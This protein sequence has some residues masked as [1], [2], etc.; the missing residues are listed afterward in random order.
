[1]RITE[2]TALVVVDAQIDFFEGGALAVPGSNA[3]LPAIQSSI[4]KFLSKG[5]PL[6]ATRDWHP[7]DHCSF[8]AQG[9]IWPP[10]CIQNTSGAKFHPKLRMPP[11]LIII[12]KADQKNKDA[13]SGFQETDLN[14]ELTKRKISEITVCGLAIDYCVKHTALDARKLNYRV[15]LLTDAIMGVNVKAGDSSNAIREMEK[16]GVIKIISGELE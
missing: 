15:Y 7:A 12:S 14:A 5:R 16:A 8:K 11:S 10:H 4:D 9:G 2:K 13:Y 6:F 3:V 1:M